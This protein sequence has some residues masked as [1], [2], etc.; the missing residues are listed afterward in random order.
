[1]LSIIVIVRFVFER[2]KI[3]MVIE[4]VIV[5]SINMLCVD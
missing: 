5:N 4:D 2:I 3:I 1:M